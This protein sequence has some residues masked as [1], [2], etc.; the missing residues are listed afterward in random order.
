MSEKTKCTNRRCNWTGYN[1]QLLS[2]Q[3]PFE[4]DEI[5]YACPKCRDT[6]NITGVCEIDKCWEE[7][8]CGLNTLDGYKRLCCNHR[9]K[10]GINK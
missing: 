8:T 10:F 3:N 6:E 2:A 4:Q 9:K 1:N 7:S 5:M